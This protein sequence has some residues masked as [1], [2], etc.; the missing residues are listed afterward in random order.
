MEGD[1]GMEQTESPV[2]YLRGELKEKDP[3]TIFEDQLNPRISL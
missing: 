1:R 2:G 3:A